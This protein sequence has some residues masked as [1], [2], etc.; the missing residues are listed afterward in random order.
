MQ[1]NAIPT[2]TLWEILRQ[3]IIVLG[4]T[5]SG[6]SSTLRLLVEFLLQHKKRVCIID[7]KGDWWGLKS[8]ADGKSEGFEMIAFGDFKEKKAQDVPINAQSGKYVAELITSG[9]RPCM[10]G[11]RGWMPGD[12]RQF[13]VDFAST[14]FNAQSG[15]LYLIVSECHNFAPKGRVEDPQIGKCIYWMNTL[16]AEGRGIGLNLLLDS[17]RPQKVHNDTLTSCETLVAMRMNHAADRKA[18]KEWIDGCGDAA[19]AKDLLDTM[20]QMKRGEG[21]VWSP[22][23]GF[24]PERVEFPLF[25]TFDS[26]APPQL[27]KK[28][29]GAGWSQVNLDDV[30]TKLAKV[31]EEAKSNDPAEL[32]REVQTLKLEIHQLKAAK[33][34][35]AAIKAEIKEVSV[36]T[37]EDKKLL[38]DTADHLDKEWKEVTGKISEFN[39]FSQK[40][41]DSFNRLETRSLSAQT[42]QSGRTP[43]S[44]QSPRAVIHR[45]VPDISRTHALDAVGYANGDFKPDKCQRA[46]LN[47]LDQFHDGMFLNKIALLAGYSI[48]NG[49]KTELSGLRTAGCITGGNTELMRITEDGRKFTEYNP[50]PE[51]GEERIKFFR[52]HKAFDKCQ[53]AVVDVL[54]DLTLWQEGLPIDEL[55]NASGYAVCNGFKTELSGLRTAGVIIGG[56]TEKMRLNP[57]MYE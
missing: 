56:N 49:F 10:I 54:S 44:V 38:K 24:G 53:R 27:Q 31:I 52:N 55:A 8:G 21:W 39:A 30:R 20:A 7:K 57:E 3:H 2:S 11:L 18:I 33:P 45:P 14:V 12:V 17:Q 29:T 4:K 35:V 47:T 13:W 50:L 40:L 28:V 6:K 37:P 5:G 43:L 48:C 15:E 22:E 19:K 32:K 51:P 16:A 42:H 23:C 26:F 9:N 25:E 36:F 1:F 34:Q 41:R 46:V